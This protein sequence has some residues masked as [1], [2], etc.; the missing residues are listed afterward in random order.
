MID[1]NYLCQFP[2]FEDLTAK[3]LSKIAPL[4]SMREYGKGEQVFLEG[5]PGNECY[6]IQSG[7]VKISKVQD[8][9]EIILAI[10]HAGDFFGEMVLLG[11]ENLR[12][13]TAAAMDRSTL[14]VLKKD[15]FEALLQQN[16]SILFKM[17]QTALERLRQANEL[18]T[19]LTITNA[20]T[21]ISRLLL[22]SVNATHNETG[23]PVI[24]IR[25]THQQIANMS[26]TVRETV[27]KVLSEW[28]SE[29][30]VRI[31]NKKIVILSPEKLSELS[32]SKNVKM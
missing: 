17:L 25:L 24:N 16:S 11:K 2:L 26:G 15:D 8:H 23:M 12:S 22:R 5:E 10:F 6:M 32:E 21:R 1:M 7:V 19:D 28:Q 3:E 14:Y 20:R 30:Y 4:F 27:S 31:D 9:K 18:I 29:N 13:A